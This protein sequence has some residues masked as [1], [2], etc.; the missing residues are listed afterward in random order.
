MFRECGDQWDGDISLT[1]NTSGG[2]MGLSS[3]AAIETSN[4]SF[5]LADCTVA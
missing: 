2:I 3:D 1:V 5:A 4:A